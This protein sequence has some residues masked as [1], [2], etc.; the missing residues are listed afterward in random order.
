MSIIGFVNIFHVH[1]FKIYSNTRPEFDAWPEASPSCEVYD[2]GE[3]MDVDILS[4][5]MDQKIIEAA[6]KNKNKENN[7]AAIKGVKRKRQKK[8]RFSHKKRCTRPPAT[9]KSYGVI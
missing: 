6:N 4:E 5:M 9:C 1:L 7:A 2:A 3:P 8:I